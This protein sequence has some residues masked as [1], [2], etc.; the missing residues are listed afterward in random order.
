MGRIISK[1]EREPK[2][3]YVTDPELHEILRKEGFK[4]IESG[5]NPSTNENYWKYED[6]SELSSI[7]V[8]FETSKR[9]QKLS[10]DRWQMTKG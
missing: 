6:S 1:P 5:F 9:R 7:K 3:T 8:P 4:E 2:Y 10:L